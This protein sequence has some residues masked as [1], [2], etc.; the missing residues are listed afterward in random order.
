[1]RSM[2][3]RALAFGNRLMFH[4]GS[5][6]GIVMTLL[7]KGFALPQQEFLNGRFVWLV[8]GRALTVRRRLVG[9]LG[10]REEVF[11]ALE[12]DSPL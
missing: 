4:S 2:A 5:G 8:A 10:L 11:V 12:A 3:R 9:D 7:A 6:Q 1:M